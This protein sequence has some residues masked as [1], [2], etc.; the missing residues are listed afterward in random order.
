MRDLDEFRF[1]LDLLRSGDVGLFDQ[2][3]DQL[4]VLFGVP[5]DQPAALREEIGARPRRK[6]NALI[7][8]EIERGLAINQ[9][10]AA[11][12]FLGVFAGSALAPLSSAGRS[13]GFAPTL[14]ALLMKPG[15]TR[16]SFVKRSLLCSLI[17]MIETA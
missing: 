12:G 13:S 11:G 4:E 7:F 8:E 2:R 3:I 15:G 1:D 5:H 10:L 6:R 14:T 9:L 17:G 16:Y